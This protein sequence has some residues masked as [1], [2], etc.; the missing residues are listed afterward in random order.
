MSLSPSRNRDNGQVTY[1]V[2]DLLPGANKKK[3]AGRNV[4]K[5]GLLKSLNDQADQLTNPS[6]NMKHEAES[7]PKWLKLT[8]REDHQQSNLGKPSSR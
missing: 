4:D 1:T 3:K 8:E 7:L 6:I 5:T 2:N